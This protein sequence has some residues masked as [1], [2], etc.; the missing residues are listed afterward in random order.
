VK[1]RRLRIKGLNSFIEEQEIDFQRLTEKGLFGIF[2]PTGS[3]KSTILDAMTLALYGAISRD[4]REYM[5]TLSS[6]LSVSYEFEIGVGGERKIYIADRVVNKDKNGLYKLKTSRL[7]EIDGEK[8][9][10]VAE[11]AN[12]VKNTIET[13]LGLTSDDFTRSVVLPQGKFNEFLRLSGKERRNMLERIFRLERFGRNLGDRIRA[14]RKEKNDSLNLLI[15]RIRSYE[16]QEVSQE[17]YEL[18]NSEINILTQ[19]E[20][21]LKQEKTNLDEMYEKYKTI[22]SL[23][24]ELEVYKNREVQLKS[25][26]PQMEALREKFKLGKRAAVVKPFIDEV[27]NIEKK[28]EANE[29]E[30]NSLTLQLKKLEERLLETELKH[31]EWLEKKEREIP[32]LIEKESKLNRALE[33]Q[34]KIKILESER[35]TLAV[36]YTS[37]QKDIHALKEKLDLILKERDASSVEKLSLEK[38]A[39]DVNINPEY[40]EEVQKAYKLEEELQRH[41]KDLSGLEKKISDKNLL[42]EQLNKKL[43][44]LIEIQSQHYNEIAVTE[45]KIQELSKNNPGD[46]KLLMEKRDM[47]FSLDSEIKEVEGYLERKKE[48]NESLSVISSEKETLE[49]SISEIKKELSDKNEALSNLEIEIKARER[50]HLALLIAADLQKGEAC[51]VCGSTEHPKVAEG[52]APTALNDKAEEKNILQKFI[53]DYEDKL[54]EK[55]VSLASVKRNEEYLS[56]ELKVIDERCKNKNVDELKLKKTVLEKEFNSLSK[57]IEEWN[58]TKETTEKELYRKKDEKTNIDKDEVKYSENIKSEKALVLVLEEEKKQLKEKSSEISEELKALKSMLGIVDVG[59]EIDKIRVFDRENTE[60]QKKLKALTEKINKDDLE[61]EEIIKKINNVELEL[62]RIAESGKEKRSVID[63][64]K[65]EL[66]ALSEGR[67]P[68]EYIRE[69]RSI[70]EEILQNE[71]MF[72]KKVETEKEEKQKVN[73]VLLSERTNNQA[74]REQK[75]EQEEKLSLALKEA[76]F[77]DITEASN[78]V[79]SKEILSSIETE[80]V[81][82]DE[83]NKDINANISRLVNKLKGDYIDSENWVKLQQD[84]ARITENLELVIIDISKK[85]QSLKELKKNLDEL[86][87]LYNNKKELEHICSN[88][89]DLAKLV[90]G[91]KFVEFVAMS[92][93]KYI[94]IEA[95]KRLKDITRGRY[96]LEIDSN[97]NFIMRDDFNGGARRATNTLSGGETFLTSL[98]LALSLSSQIQLK[99][100]APLEFFFLDEGF[101]TLDSDLLE[102]V[103]SS[104]ERL[105]SDKLCVGIISH[106]E[107]L[108]TRVPVKLIVDPAEHGKYGSKVRIELS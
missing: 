98:C 7:R 73:D 35:S 21:A 50:E 56:N 18:L 89:E 1:P 36:E 59:N 38:R 27:A 65:T 95:S 74:L 66:N 17:R 76:E 93:L 60:I 24:E 37:R 46:N 16:E 77:N 45:E 80:L 58:R 15:G 40:R 9:I 22:W 48:I 44:S 11:G 29:N 100:S 43:K 90:E 47:L 104:L 55:E 13:V 87:I 91:N 49:K 34:E 78:A 26:L 69:V 79:I 101:G 94:S 99:G 39:E 81:K 105:H 25:Q 83:A 71:G 63:R 106:V 51:P 5:N 92:Q 96:A 10:P 68:E 19:E 84:R 8:D 31:R 72:K 41:T 103:M 32:R 33:L 108:K 67:K 23:Q 4:T 54:R 3:G 62:A 42:V 28:I 61:K 57:A 85:S 30:I 102:T 86:N 82:Y 53:K 14:V 6:S 64:E 107:E 97:G 20:K 75:V 2:G 88:L 12:E 70:K 52:V